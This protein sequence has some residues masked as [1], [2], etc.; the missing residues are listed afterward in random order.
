MCHSR[1]HPQSGQKRVTKA[2][3]N[4]NETLLH[5]FGAR[6]MER[7]R[8]PRWRATI[9]CRRAVSRRRSDSGFKGNLYGTTAS[10]GEF[11][12]GV[13]FELSPAGKE[14]V[15]HSF[16]LVSGESAPQGALIQDSV[17]NLYGTTQNGGTFGYGTVF[18]LT[19]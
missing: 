16:A 11:G 4:G 19:P 5:N 18:K 12:G 7:R 15:L 2:D 6:R 3:A 9:T 14:T 13:V 1:S 17:G 8:M 10:G